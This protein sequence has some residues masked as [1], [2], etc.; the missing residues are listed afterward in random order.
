MALSRTL[1]SLVYWSTATAEYPAT[2]LWS[3]SFR[4]GSNLGGLNGPICL[5]QETSTQLVSKANSSLTMASQRSL[6]AEVQGSS[7]VAAER[8]AYSFDVCFMHRPCAAEPKRWNDSGPT[9]KRR[10]NGCVAGWKAMNTISEAVL[11]W[12]CL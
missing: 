10:A 3:S 1:L 4:L 9:P 7:S 6:A 12:K 5:L 2:G 8:A 11:P